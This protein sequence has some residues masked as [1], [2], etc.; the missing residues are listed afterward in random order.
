MTDANN[1]VLLLWFV[2]YSE[3]EEFGEEFLSCLDIP[4]RTTSLETFN[5]LNECF[6]APL[7]Q[8]HRCV[9]GR[10]CERASVDVVRR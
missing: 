9:Y 6:E 4:E 5:V 8:V 10:C 3:N 1:R 7:E 2:R